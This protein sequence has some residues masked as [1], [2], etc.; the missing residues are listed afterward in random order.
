[1]SSLGLPRLTTRLLTIIKNALFFGLPL[2]L[3]H[4]GLRRWRGEADSGLGT[5]RLARLLLFCRECGGSRGCGRM[6]EEAYG[7]A[8]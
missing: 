1:M 4:C 5:P 3:S 6:S 2:C 8:C 7:T